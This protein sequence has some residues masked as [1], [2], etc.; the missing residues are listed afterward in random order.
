MV[1]EKL[2]KKTKTLKL[3]VG[4]ILGSPFFMILKRDGHVVIKL[5]MIGIN[6]NK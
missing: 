2:I 1:V 6:S 5:F 3:H 4:I